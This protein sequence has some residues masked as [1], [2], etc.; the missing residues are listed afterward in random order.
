MSGISGSE[1][2]D[3][4]STELAV[5]FSDALGADTATEHRVDCFRTRGDG[6]Y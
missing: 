5:Y 3:F 1:E 6:D 4:A 2:A